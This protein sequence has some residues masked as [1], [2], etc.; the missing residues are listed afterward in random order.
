MKE[1][2]NQ[3]QAFDPTI[4]GDRE[5]AQRDAT[6]FYQKNRKAMD[7]GVEVSW[8][9]CFDADC[10]VSAIQH[11]YNKLIDNGQEAFDS[12]CQCEPTAAE[13][14]ETQISYTDVMGKLNNRP[15][16]QVPAAA[17]CLTGFIDLQEQSLFWLVAGW[18]QNF[19]GW[20]IDYGVFPRQNQ[21]Y[22]RICDMK[23]TLAREYPGR[24]QEGL[25]R[26]GLEE[27]ARMLVRR[28]WP[29]EDGNSSAQ[30]DKLFL[31]ANQGQAS[32]TVRTFIA[33]SDYGSTVLPYISR[34]VGASE[35]PFN[36]YH[37]KPGDRVGLNWRVPVGVGR[38]VRHILVDV[39][40]WKTF[41]KHRWKTAAGDV[42]ALSLF[43]GEPDE[44]RLFVDHMLCE[45]GV[46]VEGRGR[47]LEEWRMRRGNF[48]ENHWFDGIVGAA[49]GASTMGCVLGGENGAL[50][51]GKARGGYRVVDR[52]ELSRMGGRR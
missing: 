41:V 30:L 8:E 43:G 31:D 44:H 9:H 12:E 28:K 7:K 47:K 15:R 19:T 5:R 3:R 52:A 6:V 36:E 23:Q 26:A 2:K 46:P 10:E 4:E 48:T 20:V 27:T 32:E 22:F 50:H 24:G 49:V 42:G 18:S 39:N 1:Y 45:T 37:K 51:G 40:F 34:G 17:V 35:K 33:E 29:R 25:W 21:T 14:L 38:N 13:E 11:A 16:G